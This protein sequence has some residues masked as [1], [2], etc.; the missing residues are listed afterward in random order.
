LRRDSKRVLVTGGAGYIGSLLVP[1]LLEAGHSVTVLDSML[2]GEA[3]LSPVAGHPRL[4]IIA[5]DLRDEGVVSRALEAAP[6]TVIHLAAISNDPCSDLDPEVT[7]DVNGRCVDR[8]IDAAKR[9]GVRRFLYASSA[10]VYGVK[11]TPDVHEDLSLEPMTVYAECKAAGERTLFRAASDAFTCVAVRAA[12]VCGDSPRLRLDLTINLLTDHA[13]RTGRIR[14][15]GGAQ[16]RP[17][18][19]VR[20][21]TRFYRLLLEAPHEKVQGKAFNVCRENAS[22]AALAQRIRDAIDPTL[23]I[24][25]VPTEDNRSYHLSAERVRETLGFVAELPIDLAV[26]QLKERYAAGMTPDASSD[27]YRNVSWMKAHPEKWQREAR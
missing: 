15:F 25:V 24:E 12:T 10:S 8:L 9:A 16:M 7:R 14:V 22:V 4:A 27:W 20:D 11:S 19:H 2:F 21:L 17:N 23:P 18:I 1:E 5:A 26:T 6:D 3:P 13:L